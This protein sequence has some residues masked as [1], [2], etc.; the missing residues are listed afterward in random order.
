MN[1]NQFTLVKAKVHVST[2]DVWPVNGTEL[3]DT[4]DFLRTVEV[5]DVV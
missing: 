5:L 1:G 3:Q 2:C 4:A